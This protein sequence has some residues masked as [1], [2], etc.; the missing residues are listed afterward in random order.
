MNWKKSMPR[1][2]KMSEIDR[3]TCENLIL[4]RQQLEQQITPIQRAVSALVGRYARGLPVLEVNLDTGLIRLG[5]PDKKESN[6]TAET[7]KNLE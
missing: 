2:V 4:K 5:Q 7:P 6:S 1:Q 3:I